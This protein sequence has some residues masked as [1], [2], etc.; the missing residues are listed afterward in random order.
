MNLHKDFELQGLL[1]VDVFRVSTA[2][3]KL[4][5]MTD[6]F[7]MG[8]EELIAMVKDEQ[9]AR[10]LRDLFPGA[11]AETRKGLAHDMDRVTTIGRK[12]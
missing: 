3:E 5:T 4:P 9:K 2:P 11:V 8:W 6:L 7:M 12:H 10:P 1:D